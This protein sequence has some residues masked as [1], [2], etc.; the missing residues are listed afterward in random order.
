MLRGFLSRVF[1]SP[2]P[3]ATTDRADPGTEKNTEKMKTNTTNPR[4]YV[5]TYAKYNA[6]S[7]A[8]E[9]LDLEDY[10]S[11]AEFMEAAA[12]VHSDES[13][14]ELM[15]QDFEGFPKCWYSESGA[16]PEII[17]EWLELD[18]TERAA[19]GIYAANFH[20]AGTVDDFRDAYCGTWESE[21]DFAEQTAE[22]CGVIPKDFPAWIVIDWEATWNCNLRFDYFFERDEDGNLH[23]FRNN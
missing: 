13:D 10:S 1:I 12:A 3:V 5:G 6:G 15:F 21:A 14:P 22:D 9:W 2:L 19:F 17:W 4:L 18:E 20:G 11:P 23:I 7:I 8:G 16:P